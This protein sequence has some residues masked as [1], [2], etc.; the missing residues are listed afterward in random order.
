[1]NGPCGALHRTAPPAH[2]AD[3]PQSH[4]R[5]H[6]PRRRAVQAHGTGKFF[7]GGNWKCNGA[8]RL[9]TSP[10]AHG[11]SHAWDLHSHL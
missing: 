6:A 10:G 4:L 11:I 7:V 9:Q 5:H 8:Q 1:M 2:R 3:S